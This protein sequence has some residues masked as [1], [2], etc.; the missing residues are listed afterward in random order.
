MDDIRDDFADFVNYLSENDPD[1]FIELFDKLQEIEEL[2][3]TASDEK[4]AQI[5]NIDFTSITIDDI[6]DIINALSDE[7]DYDYFRDLTFNET[8]EY[9]YTIYLRD[10]TEI[11]GKIRM[12]GDYDLDKLEDAILAAN[13]DIDYEDVAGISAS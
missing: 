11:E 2:L 5:D 6:D 4:L 10:G 9:T 1:R 7:Y 13:G 8:N 12:Y 3:Q